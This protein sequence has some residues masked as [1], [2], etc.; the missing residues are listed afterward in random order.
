[1]TPEH[2]KVDVVITGAGM[3]G[4]T[5]ANLLAAQGK[6]IAIIDR[7]ARPVFNTNQ[8]YEARVTAVSPGSKAIFEHV[9]CMGRHDVQAC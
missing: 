8:D 6:S 9:R 7:S 5:L 1:M 3:V 4:L 2:L